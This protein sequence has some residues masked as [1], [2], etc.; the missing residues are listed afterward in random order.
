MSKFKIDSTKFMFID[1]FIENDLEVLEQISQPKLEEPKKEEPNEDGENLE[2]FITKYNKL[3]PFDKYL[4]VLE[5]ANKDIPEA[6][7]K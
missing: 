2:E 5:N 3:S 1:E 4:N 7:D 6:S